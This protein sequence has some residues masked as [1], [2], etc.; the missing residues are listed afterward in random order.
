MS[1]MF[2]GGGGGEAP[3]GGMQPQQL[4]G[5]GPGMVSAPG[6]GYMPGGG[7]GGSGGG[8]DWSKFGKGLSDF[9]KMSQGDSMRFAPLA[10]AN[11]MGAASSMSGAGAS[12]IQPGGVMSMAD[13]VRRAQ[14]RYQ[15]KRDDR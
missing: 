5:E 3:M 11:P 2:G 14:T 7:S 10:A 9:S 1:S 4:G 13:I 15:D 8:W 6:G 12:P